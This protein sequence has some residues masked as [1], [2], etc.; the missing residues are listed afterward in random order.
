ME[1]GEWQRAVISMES[2]GH[3][4]KALVYELEDLSWVTFVQ[5][6]PSHVKKIIEKKRRNKKNQY[7]M[8]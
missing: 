5:V 1:A 8:V 6:N 3:Y 4:W 2:T 7:P